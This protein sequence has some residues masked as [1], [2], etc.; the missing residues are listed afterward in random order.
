MFFPVSMDDFAYPHNMIAYCLIFSAFLP[1]NEG[2][3]FGV[4]CVLYNYGIL[5]A[6]V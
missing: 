2:Y 1:V 5:F 3:V 6:M 4:L